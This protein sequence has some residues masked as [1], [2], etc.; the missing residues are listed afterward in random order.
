WGGGAGIA[1][2]FTDKAGGRVDRIAVAEKNQLERQI[3]NRPGNLAIAIDR[4]EAQ[5][6]AG[7]DNENPRLGRSDASQPAREAPC[8][9]RGRRRQHQQGP[10]LSRMLRNLGLH[11][12]FG[13]LSL[14]AVGLIETAHTVGDLMEDSE[15]ECLV[16]AAARRIELRRDSATEARYEI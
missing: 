2:V 1:R 6:V 14:A 11:Q 16:A 7:D 8:G 5:H 4:V 15:L 9:L 10:L 3:L 13:V 12:P